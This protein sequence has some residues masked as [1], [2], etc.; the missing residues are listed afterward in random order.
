MCAYKTIVQYSNL[1]IIQYAV[2]SV[3][4]C[5]E[6]GQQIMLTHYLPTYRPVFNMRDKPCQLLYLYIT[7]LHFM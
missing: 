5:L 6:S 7:C 2:I 1:N 4:M 3:F